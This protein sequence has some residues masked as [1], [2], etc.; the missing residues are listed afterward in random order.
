M[1]GADAADAGAAVRA[2]WRS[3]STA[4]GRRRRAARPASLLGFLLASPERAADRAELIDVLWPHRAPRD[5][6]AALRPILSRLRR[7]LEPAALEGRERLRLR[8]PGPVWTDIDEAAEALAAARAAAKA[9]RWARARAHA[10]AALGLLRPGF[11]PGIDDDWAHA[12][13]LELEELELEALEWIARASLGLGDAELGAAQRAG[14]ELVARSPFRETGHRFLM[15]ALA[16]GRQRRRGPARLRRPARPAARRAR[17]RRP[18]PSCRRCTS[19]CS[20]ATAA[21]RRS[22]DEPP[23]VA[24]PPPARAARAVGVR[25]ARARAGRPARSAWDEARSGP[26]AAR[27]RGR[28]AG[29]RQDAPGDRSSRTT[30]HR[31]RDGALRRPARRRRSSPTSRSS[32]RCAAP[33][34]TGRGSRGCRGASELARLIPELPAQPEP[35]SGDAELQRYQLFEAMSSLLDEIAVAGTARAGHRRPPLGRPRARCTCCATSHARPREAPLLIV[36]TYRDAEVRP[37][38]PLADLLADLRRDRLV[39]RIALEGLRERDVGALIA[40]ARRARRARRRS[41]APSTS[42][43]TATRSSSRRCCGTSSRPASCSSAAAAG[44]PR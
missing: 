29:H 32:R 34:S 19:G 15:E 8:L 21:R 22:P 41:S 9:E 36:G 37:S 18:R 40:D 16:G 25:G 11:L 23:L 13:R 2:S 31:G 33:G 6:Q 14:R 12:R 35:A 5:P 24:A 38:H 42:T 28:R 3:R 17:N 10:N 30:A 27:G 26:P 4:S 39:E 1:G 7:A 44:P 43:P 20:S